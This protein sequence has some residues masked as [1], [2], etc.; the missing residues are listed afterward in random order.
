MYVRLFSGVYKDCHVI[1]D[2]PGVYQVMSGYIFRFVYVPSCVHI[3]GITSGLCEVYIIFIPGV[4]QVLV[5]CMSD[6]CQ[7]YVRCRPGAYNWCVSEVLQV[8]VRFISGFSACEIMQVCEM[9]NFIC[10]IIYKCLNCC[11]KRKL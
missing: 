2:M 8:Y 4:F 6:A 5:I 9:I 11:W 3:P 1:L 7:L 10:S